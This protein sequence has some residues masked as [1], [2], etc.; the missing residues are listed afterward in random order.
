MLLLLLLMMMMMLLFLL[1]SCQVL[2]DSLWPNGLQHTRLLCPSPSPGV[3]PSSCPLIQCFHPTVS[4]S[5]AFFSCCL[6]SL[7]ASGSFSMKMDFSKLGQIIIISRTRHVDPTSF[8]SV[9]S[10][11]SQGRP[12]DQNANVSHFQGCSES[13]VSE[14][15]RNRCLPGR[16]LL[17]LPFHEWRPPW[18]YSGQ[19]WAQDQIRQR[20]KIP[21]PEDN[22][23]S[24]THSAAHLANGM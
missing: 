24:R 2:S 6:Q 18:G 11:A 15:R 7:P 10:Q 22:V 17:P 5:V 9:A 16:V 19:L 4:S 3:C 21:K 8:Y 20:G 23:P 13:P 14:T 1:F 12:V